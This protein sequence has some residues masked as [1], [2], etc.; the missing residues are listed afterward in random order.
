MNRFVKDK[1]F[2]FDLDGTLVNSDKKILESTKKSIKK[3]IDNGAHVVLASGRIYEGIYHLA[4]ELELDKYGGYRNWRISAD[5]DLLYRIMPDIKMLE[6]NDVF[7]NRR[8]RE[9]SLE[10]SDD[11]SLKSKQR[12]ELNNFIKNESRKQQKIKISTVEYSIIFDNIIYGYIG[13]TSWKKRIDTVYKTID[14]LLK[15]KGF[16]IILTLSEEEFPQKEKELPFEI[17]KYKNEGQ[18]EILWIY[19]NYRSF[20]KI[21][22]GMDKYRTLPFITADDDG[23]YPTNYCE[24][25][26]KVYCSDH[27]KIYYNSSGCGSGFGYI[28][29][30]YIFKQYTLRFIEKLSSK[31]DNDD[32]LYMKLADKMNIKR[33]CLN[34]KIGIGFHDQTSPINMAQKYKTNNYRETEYNYYNSVIIIQNEID[35]NENCVIKRNFMGF[36]TSI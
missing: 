18:I 13:I 17:V 1:V 28:F 3:L 33:V 30:P 5:F 11:T 15:N 2:A 36:K 31:Y 23:L 8:V 34:D 29:P 35:I 20:K 21:L 19:K 4:K 22:F 27:T 16:K 14:T 25:L 7:Y 10:Y 6:L 12:I 9:N 26:Y 24:K 32:L